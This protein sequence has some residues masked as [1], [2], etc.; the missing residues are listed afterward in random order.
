MELLKVVGKL[1]ELRECKALSSSNKLDIELMYREVLGKDFIK[2]SC[3]DCYHDA[4]IEMYIHLKK[5]GKMKEKSNYILKNGVVLQKEFGSGDMY[6][7]ANITDEVAENYLAD[8]PKGIM[9]FSGYPA[10]W[11]N[12]VRRRVLKRESISDELIAII[13]EAFDGGVSEDSL[14]D[15]LANYELGGRKITE[16]QL[17]NHLSKAKDIIAKR[18]DAEKMDKQQEKKEEN[19]E[20]SEKTEEK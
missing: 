18:K 2:T 8:N 12:K 5:T 15:E 1:E 17:N 14:M 10:D 3:N 16:K 13:V 11:E 7:N 19:I 6:T 20:K 4:V 9:F